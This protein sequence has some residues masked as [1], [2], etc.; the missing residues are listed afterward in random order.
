MLSADDANDL[1]VPLGLFI[2]KDEPKEEVSHPHHTSIGFSNYAHVY[3][4]GYT[5]V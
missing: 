3:I 1:S 4:I 5:E 2:S